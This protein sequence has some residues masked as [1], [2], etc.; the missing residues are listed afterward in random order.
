[1]NKYLK[2]V[3]TITISEV[4]SKLIEQL[5]SKFQRCLIGKLEQLMTHFESTDM[6]IDSGFNI[7]N[8]DNNIT[9]STKIEKQLVKIFI[10]RTITTNHIKHI[11]I[12]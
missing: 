8:I 5:P 9:I 10:V 1:M 3:R 2:K 11:E 4:A 7:E 12:S 6:L